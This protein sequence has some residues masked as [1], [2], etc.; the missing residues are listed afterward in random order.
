MLIGL[1]DKKKQSGLPFHNVSKDGGSH[2]SMVETV[3]QKGVQKGGPMVERVSQNL[4]PKDP[5][6]T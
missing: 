3:S 2:S 6:L 5:F 1:R 4:T